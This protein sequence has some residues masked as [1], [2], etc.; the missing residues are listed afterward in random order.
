[1]SSAFECHVQDFRCC[2]HLSIPPD[3]RLVGQAEV[4]RLEQRA[5]CYDFHCV[6]WKGNLADIATS[7]IHEDVAVIN[8]EVNNGSDL[9]A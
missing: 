1:M 4:E 2:S 9:A 6:R 8:T 5:D 7:V 3:R